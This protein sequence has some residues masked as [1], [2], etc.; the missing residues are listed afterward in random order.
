MFMKKSQNLYIHRSGP[1]LPGTNVDIIRGNT[2]A[3][4]P[5]LSSSFSKNGALGEEGEALVQLGSTPL[6]PSRKK[7]PQTSPIPAFRVQ[8]HTY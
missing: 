8:N 6:T 5:T 4:P 1:E 2:D 7:G 3:T